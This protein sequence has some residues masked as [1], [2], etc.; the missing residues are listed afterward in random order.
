MSDVK[1][2]EPSWYELGM[3]IKLSVHYH[4]ERKR[5]F[6]RWDNTSNL[7][8]LLLSSGATI[9]LWHD[10]SHSQG[11]A[12]YLAF[13]VAVVQGFALVIGFSRKAS[14]HNDFCRCYLDLLKK[15]TVAEE[16][17]EMYNNIESERLDIE[18]IEPTPMPYLVER[19]HIDL[20]R[21]E[22]FP[23]DRWPKLNL[24]KRAFAQYL[25]EI[26]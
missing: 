4:Q 17:T 6:A 23:R 16:S 15:W 1:K 25:P 8:G 12:L 21:R 24:F 2:Q 19:C 7:L 3:G 18:K 10:S 20:M 22:G 9:A 26:G 14:Q 13:A 11:I 5:F